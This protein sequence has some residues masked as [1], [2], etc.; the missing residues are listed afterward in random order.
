MQNAGAANLSSLSCLVPDPIF[1]LSLG[2]RKVARLAGSISSI[3]LLLS[4][5]AALP[6]VCPR[7][8]VMA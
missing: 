3:I 4:Y 2:H 1:L 7:S 6:V 8:S 5:A